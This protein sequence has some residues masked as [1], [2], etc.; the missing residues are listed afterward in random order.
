MESQR[1]G[2]DWTTNTSTFPHP[3]ALL[4]YHYLSK[5]PQKWSLHPLSLFCPG[6]WLHTLWA[7]QLHYKLIQDRGHVPS[8]EQSHLENICIALHKEWSYTNVH[9]EFTSRLHVAVIIARFSGS[10]SKRYRSQQMNENGISKHYP[11]LKGDHL[12]VKAVWGVGSILLWPEK[13][14]IGWRAAAAGLGLRLGLQGGWEESPSRSKKWYQP[15]E[16]QDILGEASNPNREVKRSLSKV[17][18]PTG[19][20]QLAD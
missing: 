18:I 20:S 5:P 12:W 6:L 8:E 17:S 2:W 15:R 11:A 4:K 19:A 13:R 9:C 7:V 14:K 1:V 16:G 10:D 3:Q